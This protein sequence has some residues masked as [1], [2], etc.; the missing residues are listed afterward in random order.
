MESSPELLAP[1]A[2]AQVPL[3]IAQWISQKTRLEVDLGCGKG[4]FLADLATTE[5]GISFVGVERQ[6]SRVALCLKKIKNR[7]LE[8]VEMVCAE[9]EESVREL[10][11]PE[12]VDG[13]YVLCPDPWPKRRH[14][15]R[16]LINVEFIELVRARLKPGGILRLLTDDKP[17]FDKMVEAC[18]RALP[19]GFEIC[20]WDQ[21][22]VFPKTDFQ[23]TFESLGL[24]IQRIAIRK[25]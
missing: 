11:P 18:H 15:R 14:H 23:K 2:I 19:L 5:S 20:D 7:H 12:S 25:V 6:K 10:F 8:N 17:Y 3:R 21:G 1:A 22:R 13:F 4:G 24:S 16:R 9:C